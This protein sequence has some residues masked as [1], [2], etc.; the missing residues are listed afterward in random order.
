[1]TSAGTE[2]QSPHGLLLEATMVQKQSTT[3]RTDQPI[4]TDGE[5]IAKAYTP[6]NP[7]V[8]LNI[9]ATADASYALDVAP[10]VDDSNPPT[11]ESAWFDAEETYDQADE[12]D[13]QDIRDTFIAGDGWLRIRVTDPAADGETADVTIQQAH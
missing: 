2:I 1:M 12:P 3:D 10:E 8:S 5:I 13:P 4:D 6:G 9:E 7:I 11:D